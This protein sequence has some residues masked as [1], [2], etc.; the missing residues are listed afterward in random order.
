MTMNDS[1]KNRKKIVELL[2]DYIY[3]TNETI[4][5]YRY[6]NELINIYE[7][8]FLLLSG[9]IDKI[10]E[11]IDNIKS[12]L[13]SLYA[14]DEYSNYINTLVSLNTN[15]GHFALIRFKNRLE[16]DYYELLKDVEYL[17]NSLDKRKKYNQTA[18]ECRNLIMNNMR[19]KATNINNICVIISR[20]EHAGLISEE[21]EILLLNE[22]Q[23]YGLT[24]YKSENDKV[25]YEIEEKYGRIPNIL[26]FGYE[27]LPQVETSNKA[28]NDYVK[29]IHSYLVVEKVYDSEEI[30][31]LLEEYKGY[32]LNDSEYEYI[33]I[34]LL[35]KLLD[36]LYDYYEMLMDKDIYRSTTQRNDTINE[37][38]VCLKIYL[39][40]REIEESFNKIIETDVDEEEKTQYGKVLVY[41]GEYPKIKLLSDMD[42]MREE[43]YGTMFELLDDFK[44]GTISSNNIK[45]IMKGQNK[46]YTELKSD[47]VR[48]VIKHIKDK[49]YAIMGAFLKKGNNDRKTYA[50]LFARQIPNIDDM[51]EE[52]ILN[53]S[54]LAEELIKETVIQQGRKGSR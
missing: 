10:S 37:F 48:I 43:S 20:A 3:H 38:N 42:D 28:L 19:L 44:N 51:K 29:A 41:P 16:S 40:I 50:K 46:D 31:K 53:N 32:C 30:S 6:Y 35:N 9:G 36:D 12:M 52:D 24:R 14:D 15:D 8:L 5:K 26:Q 54:L 18:K 21:E 33:L 2:N 27:V 47:Q 13:K 45:R 11:N 7:E 23:Y 34:S 17:K 4:D 39:K 49:Y 22:M 1:D 25:R